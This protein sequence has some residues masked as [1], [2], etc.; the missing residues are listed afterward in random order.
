MYPLEKTGTCRKSDTGTTVTFLPD[1]E[2]FEKTRFKADS[3]QS[4]L[5]ETAYLNPGLTIH[6]TDNRIEPAAE[7]TYRSRTALRHM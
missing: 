1:K 4:R 3:I 6:F 7:A 2:I 5:H